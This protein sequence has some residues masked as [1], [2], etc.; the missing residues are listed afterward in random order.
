MVRN[1]A[2]HFG[3]KK[4]CTGIL[5]EQ[6]KV[7]FAAVYW[8]KNRVSPTHTPHSVRAP[9]APARWTCCCPLRDSAALPVILL[10]FSCCPPV[11]PL[12]F[13][14]AVR[15]R[16]KSNARGR[17]RCAWCARRAQDFPPVYWIPNAVWRKRYPLGLTTLPAQYGESAILSR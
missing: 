14:R 10:L 1:L 5:K 8:K 9:A 15:S 13:R 4:G 17:A 16:T 11:L 12:H 2:Y 6:C 3:V 7:Q